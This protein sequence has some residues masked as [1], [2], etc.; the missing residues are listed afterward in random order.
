MKRTDFERMSKVEQEACLQ[1]ARR[2]AARAKE[3]AVI[4]TVEADLMAGW[5]IEQRALGRPESELIWGNC[6]METGVWC[7]DGSEPL[8]ETNPEVKARMERLIAMGRGSREP[9]RKA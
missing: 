8:C 5:V 4:A 2:A 1:R 6:V 3:A 9:E 7:E